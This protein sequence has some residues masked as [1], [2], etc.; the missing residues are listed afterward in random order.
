[1]CST[2]GGC[3]PVGS[4]IYTHTDSEGRHC[5][6]IFTYCG[7]PWDCTGSS[8]DGTCNDSRKWTWYNSWNDCYKGVNARHSGCCVPGNECTPKTS[9]PDSTCTD[10]GYSASSTSYWTI[11]KK[12]SDGCSGELNKT[13]YCTGDCSL[14]S[15]EAGTS[16]NETVDIYDTYSCTN[17]CS[18]PNSKS[19]YCDI[20][21]PPLCGP[22][23]EIS[24]QGYGNTTLS[25]RNGVGAPEQAT[26]CDL[27]NRTCYCR[28]CLK[29]CPLPLEETE[30]YIFK[31]YNLGGASTLKLEDFRRC[32][33]DC[34]VGPNESN[35]DCYEVESRQPDEALSIVDPGDV[36]NPPNGYDFKSITHTGIW[37]SE[38][39]RKKDLNDPTLPLEMVATYTDPDGA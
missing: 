31:G 21:T 37:G 38:S 25:C 32:T 26:K 23:Y 10:S 7:A 12:C 11:T 1:M 30:Q 6:E 22:A 18:K 17:D 28:D 14:Q 27:T 29:A 35:D 20:C 19:C 13:C 2:S 36:V 4:I 9:C 16:T 8:S 39:T 5:A 33:N 15:C 3:V 34:N 24:D